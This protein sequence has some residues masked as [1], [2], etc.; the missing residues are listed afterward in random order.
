MKKIM[1]MTLLFL[2]HIC[3]G[4]GMP[5]KNSDAGIFSLGVRSAIGIVNDGKWQTPAFGTGG[6]FG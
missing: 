6:N 3:E 2:T 4:Q 1:L 5:T